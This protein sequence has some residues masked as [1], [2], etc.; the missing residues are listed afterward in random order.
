MSSFGAALGRHYGSD[1]FWTALAV[2]PDTNQKLRVC[3]KCNNHVTKHV[4]R[5]RH[6][7]GVC[8][9]ARAVRRPAHGKERSRFGG[10][11]L[12]EFNLQHA[13]ARQSAF[14]M[15]HTF[16][17]ADLMMHTS[18]HTHLSDL[19]SVLPSYVLLTTVNINICTQFLAGCVARPVYLQSA[20]CLPACHSAA[21]T[22]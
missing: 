21:L 17:V 3:D 13:H 11:G 2:V 1:T 19:Q 12:F 8:I 5:D 15:Q 22:S 10:K 16:P 20:A 4:Y 14:S 6:Q 18:M 9:P 7:Y